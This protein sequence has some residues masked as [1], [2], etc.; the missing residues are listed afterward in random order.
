M[1]VRLNIRFL[2]IF[3]AVS[4]FAEQKIGYLDSQ[5]ILSKY[6][7]AEEI[8]SEFQSKVNEWKQEVNRRQQELEKLQKSLETQSFM[9]TEEAKMRKLQEIGSSRG[10]AMPISLVRLTWSVLNKELM[11]PLLQ[12]IDTIVSEIAKEEELAFVLDASTGVVIYA[13][14]MYDITDKILQ[15]LNKEYMPG[16]EGDEVEYYVFRFKE[17]DADSKSRELG[18]IIKNLLLV[19]LNDLGASFEYILPENLSSAKTSLSI[20]DE[21]EVSDNVSLAVQFLNM[22]GVDFV[23]IGR[24]WVETGNIFFEYSVVDKEKEMAVVTE[25]V[26]VGV[27]ENLRDKIAKEVIPQIA[28]LY[29]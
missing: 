10:M 29:K 11:Q 22:A 9:L 5:E 1:K 8:R 6:D 4:L 17:E 2:F 15:A 3:F 13:D 20:D 16:A 12:E 28:N 18:K 21:E 26:D 27:E 14:E 7:K 23:L 25:E 24:V 19:A